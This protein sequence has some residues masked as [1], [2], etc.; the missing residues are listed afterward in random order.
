M[1]KLTA[2]RIKLAEYARQVHRVTTPEGITYPEILASEFWAHVSGTFTKGDL[3]EVFAEDSSWYAQL[4][5]LDCS[6]LHAKVAS[7][8]YQSLAVKAKRAEDTAFSVEFKGPNRKWS[9][10]R[11]KDKEI[12]K[13]NFESKDDANVWLDENRE[14]FI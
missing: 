6:R 11:K 13:E 8:V 14:T 3:I 9:V 7:L 4:L 5:V 12:V 10:I 2:D 1:S